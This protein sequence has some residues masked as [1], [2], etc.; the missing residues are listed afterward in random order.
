MTKTRRVIAILL[1]CCVTQGVFAQPLESIDTIN[2]LAKSFIEK[3]TP[4]DPGDRME[5]HLSQAANNLQL[6]RCS[7]AIDVSFPP[8]TAEQ[9]NTLTMHCT[10]PE[11]WQVYVPVSTVIFTKVIVAKQPIPSNEKIDQNMLTTAEMDKNQL[12][13]GYYKEMKDVVGLVTSG[14]IAS[15]SVINKRN[16]TQPILIK[17]NQ[18]V[19][20]VAIKG[21]IMVRADGVAKEDGALNNSIKV[22]NPSSKRVLDAIVINSSTVQVL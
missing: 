7:E 12:F 18:G 10:G 19:S 16:A 13:L 5:V 1:G 22:F 14:G 21:S 4:L 20:I 17:R 9:P 3:N 2:A 8:N 6:A 15:G 11:A